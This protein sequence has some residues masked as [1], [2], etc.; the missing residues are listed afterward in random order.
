MKNCL[1][2]GRALNESNWSKYAAKN[3]VNKCKLCLA[4]EKNEWGRMRRA[5]MDAE[6][7]ASAASRSLKY[8]EKCKAENPKRYT[9]MQMAASCKKRAKAIFKD[10]NI[11]S[12]YILSI[13]PDK[14]PILDINL[15]YGGGEK[16]PY[17]A[18]LDRIDSSK[19]Y[20][21]GNVQIVSLRAN[22]MKSDAT[23]FEM[24]KFAEWA[25][26]SYEK[27]KEVQT[28]RTQK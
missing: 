5:S 17:S 23:Q 4:N 6:G 14:C 8:K 12:S 21:V 16:S 15:R 22:L 27:S 20:V 11:D 2:C 19:G 24:V 18:S 28:D 25:L 13:M 9:A 1:L 26:R 3:Y 7:K 10:C